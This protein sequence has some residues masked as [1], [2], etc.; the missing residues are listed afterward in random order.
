[1][2]RS[3]NSH[4]VRAA[5]TGIERLT[6]AALMMVLAVGGLAMSAVGAEARPTTSPDPAI[7]WTINKALLTN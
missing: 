1:M 5:A 7:S 3:S 4:D 2:V 6:M